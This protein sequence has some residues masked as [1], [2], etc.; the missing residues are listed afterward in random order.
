MVDT[1]VGEIED[2]NDQIQPKLER[3]K[4]RKDLMTE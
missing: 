1:K 3:L 2:L 4:A